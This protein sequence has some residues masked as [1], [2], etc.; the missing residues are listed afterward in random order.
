MSDLQASVD[1]ILAKTNNKIPTIALQLGSG[2]NGIA[3]SLSDRISIPYAE[4]PGFPTTSVVG[5][6]GCLHVGN[7]NGVSVLCLQGRVHYYE[8]HGFGPVRHT[9]RTL[10]RLGVELSLIHI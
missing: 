8:G 2:L 9:I 1:Y 5:H 4:I 7:L 6:T 10:K 3:D